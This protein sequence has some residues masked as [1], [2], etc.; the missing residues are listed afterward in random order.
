M[1]RPKVPDGPNGA[2][3]GVAAR[4]ETERRSDLVLQRRLVRRLRRYRS[5]AAQS[6]R[7]HQDLLFPV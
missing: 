1:D 5:D 2:A 4:A 3:T 7:A 6:R